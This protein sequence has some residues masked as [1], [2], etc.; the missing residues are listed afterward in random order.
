M[1][2]DLPKCQE[3]R[4]RTGY[5]ICQSIATVKWNRF[6]LDSQSHDDM[7]IAEDQ[8]CIAQSIVVTEYT[9]GKQ[10]FVGNSQGTRDYCDG[11]VQKT[12]K[13]GLF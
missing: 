13:S 1:F 4:T 3:K 2:Y 11:R 10:G 6:L 7:V 5:C 8:E 12:K 9:W